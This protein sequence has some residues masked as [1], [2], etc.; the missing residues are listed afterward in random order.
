M[1]YLLTQAMTN[2]STI[3][4]KLLAVQWE[5]EALTKD[6]AWYNYKY[7]DINQI[8]EKVIPLLQKQK[9]LLLQPLTNIDGQSA[10]QT[11]IV[12][13]DS[14]ETIESSMPLKSV[15]DLD[16]Q[17]IWSAVTYYRRY[18]LQS[19][20]SL[21]AEDDDGA[22]AKPRQ[23]STAQASGQPTSRIG[24]KALQELSDRIANETNK[25]A[26]AATCIKALR[27]SW[28]WVS[29]ANA[30]KIEDMYASKL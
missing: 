10:I 6:Q 9:L 2:K 12:D 19:M 16:P 22:K 4:T 14:G 5:V 28:L 29:K 17:K 27:D 23:W 18:A 3:Y 26:D 25:Y 11:I 30:K 8:L 21:Q 20:L 7:F 1:I 15:N 24:D 13:T